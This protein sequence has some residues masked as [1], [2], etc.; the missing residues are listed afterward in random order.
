MNVEDLKDKARHEIDTPGH[1]SYGKPIYTFTE[2]QLEELIKLVQADSLASGVTDAIMKG[3]SYEICVSEIPDSMTLDEFIEEWK[4]N[5]GVLIPVKQRM[6]PV[7]VT[8]DESGHWYVI[9]AG[10][11][12]EFSRLEEAI[13]DLDY[14]QD[15]IDMFELKF[16]KYRTGGGINNV[17]L[18]AEI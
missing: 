10:L 18:F 2:E 9:P 12:E 5:N 15:M 7:Y 14:D 8:Q 1:P 11:E 17:Q 3:A 6:R 16:A 13:I 4:K